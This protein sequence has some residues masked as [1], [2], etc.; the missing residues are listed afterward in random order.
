MPNVNKGHQHNDIQYNNIQHNG[1][2]YKNVQ[3]NDIHNND[4]QHNETQ[5]DNQYHHARCRLWLRSVVFF[6]VIHSVVML[7]DLAPC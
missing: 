2:Q 5:H 1:I 3:H 6:I 7:G 4:I